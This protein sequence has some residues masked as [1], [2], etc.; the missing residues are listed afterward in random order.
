MIIRNGKSVTVLS[1]IKIRYRY[2]FINRK[3][4]SVMT[5]SNGNQ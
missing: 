1:K 2:Y 3:L 5:F 4:S